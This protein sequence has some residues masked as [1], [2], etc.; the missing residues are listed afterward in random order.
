M[1]LGQTYKSKKIYFK[2]G[3]K[4]LILADDDDDMDIEYLP[5][6]STLTKM[7]IQ[8]KNLE[9][10]IPKEIICYP[11]TNI[12]RPL[13]MFGAFPKEIKSYVP[14]VPP[15]P[16]NR[17]SSKTNTTLKI[18]SSSQATSNIN[19][20]PICVYDRKDNSKN[21]TSYSVKKVNKLEQYRSKS[22]GPSFYDSSL[23]TASLKEEK[24]LE[25]STR[26]ANRSLYR[27]SSSSPV[28]RH[29]QLNRYH[30]ESRKS[31]QS[32]V[33][34]GRGISKE[35]T[36]AE[37]KKKLEQN[38]FRSCKELTVSTSILRNPE[39]KSP[40]EVKKALRNSLKPLPC[41][42]DKSLKFKHAKKNS[43]VSNLRSSTTLY[44]SN[45]SISNQTET[46]NSEKSMKVS[47]AFSTGRQMSRSLSDPNRA[48]DTKVQRMVKSITASSSASPIRPSVQKPKATKTVLTNSNVSLARTSSTYS[49]D[50]T[51]SKR[52][53]SNRKTKIHASKERIIPIT[54]TNQNLKKSP[55]KEKLKLKKKE[56]CKVKTPPSKGGRQ[57]YGVVESIN[58]AILQQNEAIRSD[59]FFQNLFL[60]DQPPL[61]SPICRNTSV[62]EKARQWNS[63][64][65]KSEPSL[66][67]PNYYLS[68]ARPVSSSK[69]KAMES[70]DIA[71]QNMIADARARH[72]GNVMEQITRF[73]SYYQLSDEE[74]EF[75]LLSRGRS[76]EFNYSYHERSKSEP[77][78]KT[79]IS[80]II[81]PNTPLVIHGKSEI[82]N[83]Y[84]RE[85]Q[86]RSSRSPSCR[87]IQNIKGNRNSS[88]VSET[89]KRIE[90]A[91]SLTSADRKGKNYKETDLYRS[92]SLSFINY[93]K[94]I[95]I[96]Y[97]RQSD[98]F[99]DLNDFYSSLERIGHLEQV[100]SSS[101]LRPI[102]KEEDI[103][104]FDLWKKIR[105]QERAERELRTLVNKL[106]EDQREKDLLYLPHDVEEIR[107]KSDFDSGL[108]NKEKS[109]EDIKEELNKHSY[110]SDFE[111]NKIR[112]IESKRDT[113]KNLWRG[114]SVLDTASNMSVKYN[115]IDVVPR[116]KSAIIQ[117]AKESSVME[118]TRFGLSSKLLSTL[119]N[120][121][122]NRLKTQLSEIYNN[123]GNNTSSEQ[124][125]TKLDEYRDKFV[126]NVPEKS[127]D[128]K[129]FLK[130]RSNSLLTKQQ[131]LE[132]VLKKQDEQQKKLWS[133]SSNG[134]LRSIEIKQT[135]EE[136]ATFSEN[137]K[138][139]L[140]QFLCREIKDK[141]SHKRHSSHESDRSKIS[142]EMGIQEYTPKREGKPL[143]EKVRPASVC[144]T[145]SISSETS[146]KTVIFRANGLKPVVDDIK[147][148]IKYFEERAQDESA[149]TTIYHAREDSSPDEEE[150]V[151]TIEQKMKLKSTLEM[152]SKPTPKSPTLS[153]AQSFTDLRELFG[154]KHT[155]RNYNYSETSYDNQKATVSV[156]DVK[157]SPPGTPTENNYFTS[158]E[159]VE[160][161][162]SVTPDG[163][164]NHGG[165]GS[166]TSYLNT[167]RFGDVRKI[168][169]KFESLD[170]NIWSKGVE[171]QLSPRRFQSDPDLNKTTPV[172]VCNT[173]VKSHEIGDVSR[174]THKYELKNTGASRARSR[175][176]K[177]ISPIPKHNMKKEDR[178]MPHINVISKTASLKQEIRKYPSS[179][180]PITE[181][182]KGDVDKIKSKF[183]SQENL[184][185][186]GKMYTSA[187]DFRELK[188]I[189]S[190]LSGSWV[191][192]KFPKPQDNARSLKCPG[193][194]P[195]N[196][197]LVR[198]NTNT[199]NNAIVHLRSNSTSPPRTKD[200]SILK[201][202]YDIFADQNFDPLKH[203]PKYRYI[204]ERQF[205]ADYLWKKALEDDIGLE[206][207]PSAMITDAPGGTTATTTA[208][209]KNSVKFQGGL[210]ITEFVC[211]NTLH[212]NYLFRART[213]VGRWNSARLSIL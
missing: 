135:F 90:R 5:I 61:R 100:T 199:G 37:E 10:I 34:F 24:N 107:W 21:L 99:R 149:G 85:V 161:S 201:Q 109:V 191:A 105:A 212:Y 196:T 144:E 8:K 176:R 32:P 178:F 147:N 208:I 42:Q 29:S 40:N 82:E 187:P 103:I 30:P 186:L 94:H 27:A 72:N 120:D 163:T 206:S 159:I 127:T 121:Q 129:T 157:P 87:K 1:V 35:R 6:S 11:I 3:K 112:E 45:K 171:E 116:K 39:L 143:V 169:D 2:N 204:P 57:G 183:E 117:P 14:I 137:E 95:P 73:D 119:S 68:Q 197:N 98:R 70:S 15:P 36:F 146:N 179:S 170:C 195:E 193:K 64:N 113:Y 141:M 44:S 162:H 66:R 79:F 41:L 133:S 150:I 123:N 102:R 190:Y 60:R 59:S 84:K 142:N 203:R 200:T 166:S 46:K 110:F 140:S 81:K 56:T 23:T 52:K 62:L 115:T 167:V 86:Q 185:L 33:A 136:K 210:H 177:V 211:I 67:L 96:C 202:F 28:C 138:K 213:I 38:L 151:K 122:M 207:S 26:I 55:S 173:K 156:E 80:E 49:I 126:I 13:D 25:N 74:E 9:A 118:E 172:K 180:S 104:D 174:I 71:Y 65:S 194:I 181:S 51:N 145:E 19:K 134:N 22:A 106:K 139:K 63:L 205:D 148:K 165:G 114:S 91:R 97:H 47:V 4:S 92:N 43:S 209:K 158:Y 182:D 83:T 93:E 17:K 128:N 54:I 53:L 155:L 125:F 89:I 154:E 130:V 124:K 153:S 18:F 189:S 75:G 58:E 101:D 132:P 69:F 20:S 168:K 160:R 50:S 12:T 88:E 31:S 131:L 188:D 7:R 152:V 164:R 175:T 184:S 108:R 76:M 78:A 192:H 198:R 16:P 111:N 48:K 77:P